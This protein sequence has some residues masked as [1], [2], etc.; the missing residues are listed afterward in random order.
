[1]PPI[2]L[3]HGFLDSAWT[4]HRVAPALAQTT[5]KQVIAP[6]L[7]GHGQSD[8]V[9]AG[10]YYHF[11]DYVADVASFGYVLGL[12]TFDLVGHS[13][14]GSVAAYV[15]ATLP[16]RIRKL[17]LIEG[18]G[19]EESPLPLPQRLQTWLGDCANARA[20]PPRTLTLEV[21]AARLRQHDAL[22]PADEAA[23]LAAALTKPA[24]GSE[25][26]G[27]GAQTT[28]GLVQF[29]HDPLHVTRGP[30]PF[31]VAL[32]SQ[33]WDAIEAPTLVIDAALTNILSE[34]DRTARRNHLRHATHVV[35]EN[36]GHM[37]QRHQPD[38]LAA[39]IAAF[40]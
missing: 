40:L 24:G 33:C 18:L 31:S 12:A 15:A 9:G 25:G 29:R 4:W 23:F 30:Y 26:D 16:A 37:V 14:G 22:C 2:V 13:M 27:S 3:L 6:D 8:W 11:L 10:G 20:K 5:G 34:A 19:P 7:R 39:H 17:V 1:M 32:A 35:V 38:A 28:P 36:A 21:A